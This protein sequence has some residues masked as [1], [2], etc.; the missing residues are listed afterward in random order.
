[1]EANELWKAVQNLNEPD[2]QIVYL[3]YFMDLSVAET[4]EVLQVAEGRSNHG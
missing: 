1:M 4:A 2:Q 3:R